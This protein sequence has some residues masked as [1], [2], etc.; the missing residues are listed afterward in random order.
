MTEP[1]SAEGA[2]TIL[3]SADTPNEF[4]P[5]EFD[6]KSEYVRAH[7]LAD[8]ISKDC[9]FNVSVEN[10]SSFQD[11]SLFTILLLKHRE[12]DTVL[13]QVLISAF[14]RIVTM[15][16]DCDEAVRTKILYL[17]KKHEYLYVPEEYLT[18]AYNGNFSKFS[19]MT[20]FQRYFCSFYQAKWFAS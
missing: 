5:I 10:P 1:V 9:N 19:R 7:K 17:L 11:G 16:V 4:S 8:D 20:W 2:R 3:L 13:G 6:V 18:G 12:K 15:D 14:G